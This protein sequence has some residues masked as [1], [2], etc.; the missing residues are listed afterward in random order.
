[1][2]NR[3][4]VVETI[5]LY[6]LLTSVAA[7]SFLAEEIGETTHRWIN[8]NVGFVGNRSGYLWTHFGK[9]SDGT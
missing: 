2:L 3:K 9:R 1:M 5:G 6:R 4:A 7:Q 8:G